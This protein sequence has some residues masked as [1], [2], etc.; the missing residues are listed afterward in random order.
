MPSYFISEKRGSIISFVAIDIFKP[1]DVAVH[2]GVSTSLFHA[3][4]DEVKHQELAILDTILL[5]VEA[6]LYALQ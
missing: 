3:Y 6:T 1:I 2:E 5:L 4:D